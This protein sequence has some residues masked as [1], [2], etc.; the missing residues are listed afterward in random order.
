MKK[1][2]SV[3]SVVLVLV[4]SCVLTSFADECIISGYAVDYVPYNDSFEG[5]LTSSDSGSQLYS[6]S[7]NRTYKI[8]S[9]LSA[10]AT[11]VKP[12]YTAK[13]II[14]MIPKNIWKGGNSPTITF[15]VSDVYTGVK[16]VWASSSGSSANGFWHLNSAPVFTIFKSERKYRVSFNLSIKTKVKGTFN[17]YLAL[18]SNTSEPVIPFC[19]VSAPLS[20]G[21]DLTSS[22]RSYSLE[23]T[24]P[25]AIDELT[26][27]VKG[28]VYGTSLEFYIN[29]FTVTDITTE[30]LDNSLNKFGDRL[31]NSINPSVPYNEFDDGSFK[32][33]ANELKEAEN[34]L[35]TVDFNAIDELASSVDVS[36]YAQAFSGINQLFIRVVDTIGITPLIFFACF[37]GFCIFLIGRKLSGG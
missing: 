14:N 32:D 7:E 12:L 34:A 22:N 10:P 26:P 31:E 28:G 23:F 5:V 24:V 27:V 1:L 13:S 3:L 8:S 29:D 15:P 17:F 18:P 25:N 9:V 21:A 4:F 36:S 19:S 35:P 2:I 16:Y 30:D 37:F 11:T 6:S 33:S 20:G